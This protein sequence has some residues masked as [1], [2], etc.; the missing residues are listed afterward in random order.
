M[1][2][3]RR[4][5]IRS[6][7]TMALASTSFPVPLQARP[8][9][10]RPKPASL[11][12]RWGDQGDGSYINPVLPADY[13][14]IDV[15][16]AGDHF[17]AI[18]STMHVV[19]G[20]VVLKS[21]DLVNWRTV[22]HAIPDVSALG[23]ELSWRNM[24]AAGRGIWAGAIRYHAGRYWIYFT[25]PD[26]GIFLTTA[27]AAEGPWSP[28]KLILAAPGYDDP[29]PFWDEDGQAYLVATHF[30]FDPATKRDYE[31]H[32]FRLDADGGLASTSSRIIHHS[33]GSEANKLYRIDGVYLHYYSEV[34]A[35]GRVPMMARARS[36]EGPWEHRQL[37]HV[38]PRTDKEPN[39][40]GLVEAPDGSWWF[41]TQQGTGDWE[42][43]AMCL[44]P[45][46]WYDGWPV[47]GDIGADGVGRMVWHA[48]KPVSGGQPLP[49][50]L[51]D[52]FDG[53][54]LDPRWEWNHQPRDDMWS[55]TERPGHLRLHAFQPARAGELLAA[56]NTISQ[57]AWRTAR[58]EVTAVMVI[59]QMSSG[60]RAG[61][62]HFSGGY[63]ALGV[64]QQGSQRTIVYRD[65]HG[66][67][68]RGPVLRSSRVW[69]RSEWGFDGLARASYSED[70]VQFQQFGRLYRLTWGNYR[71]DRVGLYSLNPESVSGFVD[72]A[73]F[74]YRIANQGGSFSGTPLRGSTIT[75]PIAINHGSEVISAA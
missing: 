45:V 6:A 22:G 20:M 49:P 27:P 32:L 64:E 19:P 17:I 66:L 7:A 43:R 34:R 18:S 71:G 55:L 30:A 28:L 11:Q 24:S 10:S 38:D 4:H 63:A 15:I 65:D 73:F 2:V 61:L 54:V 42:G 39:Q 40:G 29:C 48:R 21:D 52:S 9:T 13:S 59:D 58:N 41:L 35:E 12:K 47:I 62:V 14:D 1:A 67:T 75:A 37:L 23:P 36:L 70:G 3:T 33:Q 56:G 51:S 16:R 8:S 46:R 44:L 60:Q 74:D 57:R 26:S 50:S 5:L 25:C 31:V 72:I 53:A 68:V 69:L